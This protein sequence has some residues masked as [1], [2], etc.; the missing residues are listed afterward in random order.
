MNYREACS[1]LGISNDEDITEDVVKKKYRSLA[2][3]F[4]P[5]KNVDKNTT[6]LFQEIQE[7]NA[8]LLERMDVGDPDMEEG[9]SGDLGTYFHMVLSLYERIK[10]IH[11]PFKDRMIQI[12]SERWRDC[13]KQLYLSR[14]KG[15][16]REALF[17]L[18]SRWKHVLWLDDA[19]LEGLYHD[20]HSTRKRDIV[21]LRPTMDLLLE[22]Q[23]FL[24]S[25]GGRDYYIPLWIDEITFEEEDVER[26]FICE[27]VLQEN[28]WIDEENNIHISVEKEWFD[29]GTCIEQMIGKKMFVFERKERSHDTIV[30]EQQGIPRIHPDDIY[31]ASQT[32]SIVL[33]L[34]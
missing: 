13:C 32:G 29:D 17:A 16:K 4:H 7:A 24:V 27:P 31:D 18:F 21:V 12:L 15:N 20:T 34:L 5:D 19:F 25:K 6:E 1:I 3:K 23:I 10:N 9:E 8:F 26:V 22:K 33:H 30:L 28:M 14:E 11:H 2:L